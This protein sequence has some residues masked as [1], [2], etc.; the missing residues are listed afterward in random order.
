[1]AVRPWQR[2][3]RRVPAGQAR[4]ALSRKG[5]ERHVAE[6]Q[7][8]TGSASQVGFRYGMA[9]KRSEWQAQ[10]GVAWSVVAWLG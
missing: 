1:M 10:L 3:V 6:P 7:G 2:K 4:R 5:V 9:G 8:L